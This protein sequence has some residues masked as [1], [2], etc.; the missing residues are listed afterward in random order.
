MLF[1]G[2]NQSLASIGTTWLGTAVAAGGL[3]AFAVVVGV[4]E[5]TMARVRL[6]RVPQLLV[7][8]SALSG[9]ALVLLAR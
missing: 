5:S 4:I 2:V 8:A 3:L 9:F 7:A 1:P 6:A